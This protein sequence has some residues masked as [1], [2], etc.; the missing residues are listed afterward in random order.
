MNELIFL[1]EKYKKMKRINFDRKQNG[2]LS[3]EEIEEM[4]NIMNAI[5]MKYSQEGK[6]KIAQSWLRNSL[7]EGSLSPRVRII[8]YN[9]LACVYKQSN[10][11]EKALIYI[12]KAQ[13]EA[14][15][16]CMAAK[17]DKLLS[18]ITDCSLNL[19]AILSAMDNH[20]YALK[21]VR[22]A[23]SLLESNPP[24]P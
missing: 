17:D 11:L 24:L 19:C 22:K 9:N 13:K 14:D 1:E 23:I 6:N 4:G 12:N 21:A 10:D 20:Y 7:K 16:L 2:E 8:T 3:M 18:I 5:A 15:H